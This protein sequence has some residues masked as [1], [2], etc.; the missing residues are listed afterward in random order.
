MKFQDPKYVEKVRLV[1]K[2]LE[3]N[4]ILKIQDFMKNSNWEEDLKLCQNILCNTLTSENIEY[5]K[6]K[7]GS[8]V[9]EHK[10]DRRNPNEYTL[11]LITNWIMEDAILKLFTENFQLEC[12]LSGA[13]RNREFLFN[14]TTTSDFKLITKNKK[15]QY[16]EVMNDFYWILEKNNEN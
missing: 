13:D 6:N 9:L 10:K 15:E 8:K 7:L 1:N 4:F 3:T 14:P 16:I 11:D 12:R 2:F 5:L